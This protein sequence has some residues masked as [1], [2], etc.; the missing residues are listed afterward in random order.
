M[1]RTAKADRTLTAQEQTLIRHYVREGATDD[2]IPR[3]ARKMKMAVNRAASIL[4][5][6]HVAA[7]VSRRK[8]L[9]E[10]EQTRLD[11]QDINR[12]E[13]KEEE[14]VQLTEDRVFRK[15]NAIIE[16]DPE[17]LTDG[18]RMMGQFLKLALVVTGTIRDGRTERLIPLQAGAGPA[19]PTFYRSIYQREHEAREAEAEGA[20]LYPPEP[21]PAAPEVKP[22]AAA[23]TAE[24]APTE[25]PD[26]GKILE[27]PVMARGKRR[28]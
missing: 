9:L 3:A 26:A 27:V 17:K 4:R 28:R 16:T 6:I 5:R 18:H 2:K 23:P 13:N 1:T 15:L 24:P 8:R 7:E 12:R 21:L 22:A 11:A 25:T 10:F 20:D 19:A 14:R